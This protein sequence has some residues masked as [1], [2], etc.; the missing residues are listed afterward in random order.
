MSRRQ[1]DIEEGPGEYI[2]PEE[3]PVEEELEE[4][5]L[6]DSEFID[7]SL[8]NDF[9]GEENEEDP[10]FYAWSNGLAFDEFTVRVSEYFNLLIDRCNAIFH[11]DIEEL[12]G[13]N[14][15]FWDSKFDAIYNRW[16]IAFDS[17]F[18][19]GKGNDEIDRKNADAMVEILRDN[20]LAT[21]L[22]AT[23]MEKIM[24]IAEENVAAI[25]ASDANRA[26]QQSVEDNIFGLSKARII[27]LLIDIATLRR[28]SDKNILPTKHDDANITFQDIIKTRK[29]NNASREML[30]ALSNRANELYSSPSSSYA[31]L[32]MDDLTK[33]ADELPEFYGSSLVGLFFSINET[34]QQLNKG[35]VE[36]SQSISMFSI[37]EKWKDV[38]DLFIAN[39]PAMTMGLGHAKTF[40]SILVS[41]NALPNLGRTFDLEAVIH[42]SDIDIKQ[43]YRDEK[44]L[45][46]P[47]KDR[48]RKYIEA[49][50]DPRTHFDVAESLVE[51]KES[52][53]ELEDIPDVVQLGTFAKVK[54]ESGTSASGV[55]IGTPMGLYTG[56]VFLRGLDRPRN[57]E[58]WTHITRI[59]DV[60]VASDIKRTIWVDGR[61][62]W[63]GTCNHKWSFPG[64]YEFLPSEFYKYFSSIDMREDGTMMV[65][66]EI[67]PGEEIFLDYGMSYW[68]SRARDEENP[69]KPNWNIKGLDFDNIAGGVLFVQTLARYVELSNIIDGQEEAKKIIAAAD[70][71]DKDAANDR[72][73]A[74]ITLQNIESTT[75]GI[76]MSTFIQKGKEI[77]TEEG[78]LEV[79]EKMRRLAQKGGEA[80]PEMQRT[81]HSLSGPVP[82]QTITENTPSVGPLAIAKKFKLTA[83]TM[84]FENDTSITTNDEKKFK[85]R[86]KILKKALDLNRRERI[87]KDQEKLR[88]YKELNEIED[89]D[90]TYDDMMDSIDERER[91]E[92]EAAD[93][94][95]KESRRV[96]REEAAALLK[97]QKEFEKSI[98]EED[99]EMRREKKESDKALKEKRKALEEQLKSISKQQK[100]VEGKLEDRR[101]IERQKDKERRKREAQLE[102]DK[103]AAQAKAIKEAAKLR[104]TDYNKLVSKKWG[105]LRIN[106]KEEQIKYHAKK[107]T[108]KKDME[109]FRMILLLNGKLS[110]RLNSWF[111]EAWIALTATGMDIAGTVAQFI[112]EDSYSLIL[113]SNPLMI[114]ASIDIA[115]FFVAVLQ[116]D[117]DFI[118]SIPAFTVANAFLF[119]ETSREKWDDVSKN[120]RED[121]KNY[122]LLTVASMSDLVEHYTMLTDIMAIVWTANNPSVRK[123]VMYDID[124]SMIR[125]QQD[126]ASKKAIE[127]LKKRTLAVSDLTMTPTLSTSSMII[128]P[129]RSPV[130]SPDI[131]LNT[132]AI[133]TLGASSFKITP[134]SNQLEVVFSSLELDDVNPEDDSDTRKLKKT[135]KE[136]R[137]ALPTKRRKRLVEPVM[138][139][140]SEIDLSTQPN[141]NKA[142]NR[143]KLSSQ[144]IDALYKDIATLY[145]KDSVDENPSKLNVIT[146]KSVGG[147]LRALDHMEKLTGFGR[148]ST[149]LDLG[150]GCGG[151]SL[152]AASEFKVQSVVA[153]DWNAERHQ[154]YNKIAFS[155][156]KSNAP[157]LD[158]SYDLI[159]NPTDFEM[160]RFTHLFLHCR[161]DNNEIPK[162]Q[163]KTI[164]L[165]FNKS[166]LTRYIGCSF[167][168][169]TM[170]TE[171]G[172]NVQKRKTVGLSRLAYFGKVTEKK[173]KPFYVYE[174]IVSIIDEPDA[175]QRDGPTIAAEEKKVASTKKRKNISMLGSTPT[176]PIFIGENISPI[177]RGGDYVDTMGYIE[178]RNA[179]FQ[180]ALE[181]EEQSRKKRKTAEEEM[182]EIADEQLEEEIEA[183]L[184]RLEGKAEMSISEEEEEE[185]EGELTTSK[186]ALSRKFFTFTDKFAKDTAI[187]KQKLQLIREKEDEIARLDKLINSNSTDPTVRISSRIERARAEL[188]LSNAER[189]LLDERLKYADT[190]KDLEKKAKRFKIIEK[191]IMLFKPADE[192]GVNWQKEKL[193]YV[194]S[195]I[196]EANT[197]VED[198]KIA[199]Q[200]AITD[201][202]AA[203][204]KESEAKLLSTKNATTKSITRMM[205][206]NLKISSETSSVE[207]RSYPVETGLIQ[208]LFNQET[209]PR[210]YM[211][212]N[213]IALFK[214][215]DDIRRKIKTC[216]RYE[217][218]MTLDEQ[219][220]LLRDKKVHVDKFMAWIGYIQ[221]DYR[222][223][224][225]NQHR[226][227]VL[228]EIVMICCEEVEKFERLSL[229]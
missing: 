163:M 131:S 50:F 12:N 177:K 31:E 226:M 47:E 119:D 211:I 224:I 223:T 129:T 15:R 32:E 159:S 203:K 164:A 41:S 62:E 172:F 149:F 23:R 8:E 26:F 82:I 43:R 80:L 193:D 9:G 160:D 49:R 126:R 178:K 102:R 101:K 132:S 52:R 24:S 205:Q 55:Y 135:E 10:S 189:E 155:K 60:F 144:K 217:S 29:S 18:T 202:I 40:K 151:F 216:N 199:K 120:A 20:T 78:K 79:K 147:V 21:L 214:V 215:R 166:I 133:E 118:E 121:L 167:G 174:K 84:L 190:I 198:A 28:D 195:K 168:F 64:N 48:L 152:L 170:T 96:E 35:S 128:S 201:K 200:K 207:T 37:A 1:V 153:Y 109:R 138:S 228:S 81:Y 192:V 125:D 197:E 98:R 3:P 87:A 122:S 110:D 220:D 76:G 139:S 107:K 108:L 156:I 69:I 176:T 7:D 91:E 175:M 136:L 42:N 105:D 127:R 161:W 187:Q 184:N 34:V 218:K 6:E 71:Y 222:N 117:R 225:E 94:I 141:V 165:K 124:L 180:L 58:E 73:R 221:Y 27:R 103:K 46:A 185:E 33:R 83:I 204:T 17:L 39:I 16:N 148:D 85:D 111:T 123:N 213:K 67:N 212:K 209:I 210:S 106:S 74:L 171:F 90:F 70:A 142:V 140:T 186:S 61:G 183:E 219:K 145:R 182:E 179:S 25:D 44:S 99:I 137:G 116:Y 97:E 19:V 114:S 11:P 158:I 208:Y 92:E 115:T 191:E 65:L 66:R 5:G 196:R 63:P 77:A 36:L 154:K 100:I 72:D 59:S 157:D 112:M 51:I 88:E 54:L 22:F 181:G 30:L 45:F 150:F 194:A 130:S 56:K 227:F 13:G 93:V 188:A 143:G 146:F 95:G 89:P 169:D 38:T 134:T 57:K 162:T 206:T 86:S 4:E 2:E 104:E 173:L 75:G 113:R 229:K 68:E 14:Q 53:E